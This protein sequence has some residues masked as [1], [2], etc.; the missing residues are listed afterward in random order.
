M[1]LLFSLFNS[2]KTYI[3]KQSVQK[4]LQ[5]HIVEEAL[6]LHIV[7]V[8]VL[9]SDLQRQN[10]YLLV[11]FPK[12]GQGFVLMPHPHTVTK[13]LLSLPILGCYTEQYVDP[14]YILV[15]QDSQMHLVLLVHEDTL[16]LLDQHIVVETGAL[17][18]DYKIPV[19]N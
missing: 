14:A 15:R 6:A 18:M 3:R 12:T 19:Q 1:P 5:P 17:H 4:L 8:C 2:H 13:Q 11:K 16:L 10:L 7:V 9:D